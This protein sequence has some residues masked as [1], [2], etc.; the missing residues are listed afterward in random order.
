MGKFQ[1]VASI[2]IYI[3]GQ[4]AVILLTEGLRGKLKLTNMRV[5]ANGKQFLKL[6]KN[7]AKYSKIFSVQNLDF[8]QNCSKVSKCIFKTKCI[9]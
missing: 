7:I 3:S 2:D 1:N 8:W 5:T 9:W 6:M 4:L